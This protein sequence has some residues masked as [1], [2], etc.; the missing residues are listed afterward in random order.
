LINWTLF[1]LKVSVVQKTPSEGEKNHP[2]SRRKS[3]QNY[4][5][6]D[7]LAMKICKRILKVLKIKQATQRVMLNS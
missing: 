7:V 1:K 5:P 2:H 3:L 4:I 6:F